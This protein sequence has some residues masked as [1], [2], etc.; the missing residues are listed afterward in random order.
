MVDN[1]PQNRFSKI[2]FYYIWKVIDESIYG[3]KLYDAFFSNLES[4][5]GI[6]P[7]LLGC[8]NVV[9]PCLFFP[10]DEADYIWVIFQFIPKEVVQ[11]GDEL[12]CGRCM[13]IEVF[14]YRNT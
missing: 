14:I 3:E 2:C 12:Y 11:N 4:D 6:W 9:T 10:I 8:G 13:L 1:L 5:I 7:D